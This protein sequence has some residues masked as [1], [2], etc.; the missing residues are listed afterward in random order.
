[1]D[2]H[3]VC[4]DFDTR[5]RTVATFEARQ[6]TR[7]S[8]KPDRSGNAS[9]LEPL[10]PPLEINVVTT[11]DGQTLEI[12]LPMFQLGFYLTQGTS[13]IMSRDFK[14]FEIDSKQSFDTLIGLRN[15]LVLK[16]SAGSDRRV[17]IPPGI[18]S[19]SGDEGHV[20]VE[21][22]PTNGSI[23]IYK[24]D[25]TL[26]I[27]RDN[28]RLYNKLLLVYLHGLTSF[29]LPDP[30]TCHTGTEQSLSLLRG[31][32]VRSFQ[33]LTESEL[34]LL[35]S[36]QALTPRRHFCPEQNKTVQTVSWD[37]RLPA[38][39]QHPLYHENVRE[40]L[41]QAEITEL[42]YPEE[43]LKLPGLS[44]SDAELL[45]RDAARTSVFR[46]STFG[47]EAFSEGVDAKYQSRDLDLD[48]ARAGRARKICT[49][50]F[51]H[52][53]SRQFQPQNHPA[54]AQHLSDKFKSV[55]RCSN[56]GIEELPA[57]VL[58]YDGMYLTNHLN[59]WAD[60]W[61]WLHRKSQNMAIRETGPFELM[62]WF[63]TMA[64][65]AHADLD[66][67]HTAAYFFLQAEMRDIQLPTARRLRLQL[68]HSFD[69]NG[70]RELITRHLIPESECPEPT[71]IAVSGESSQARATRVLY[72]K[73]KNKTKA[74]DDLLAEIKKTMAVL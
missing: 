53:D 14:G 1:M 52:S 70:L 6:D 8:T 12:D 38:L 42:F 29:C 33:R 7:R 60:L 49:I 31:A 72:T 10:Q 54:L 56:A 40:I 27:L 13:C 59:H 36:I 73:S 51:N 41:Q 30:F 28:G 64:F 34:A 44:S 47:S 66:I 21:I 26:G 55:G 5:W 4:L 74:V 19:F 69:S 57:E 20:R 11:E 62:M 61:C 67:T 23:H 9:I 25:Q 45:R 16:A 63:A 58:E 46:T 17:L 50:L 39:S 68:G 32:A 35:Q 48:S 43:A 24:V 15:K 65:D 3:H 71:L 37:L 18:I 2:P 22:Q